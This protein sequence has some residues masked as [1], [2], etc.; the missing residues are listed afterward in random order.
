MKK[1]IVIFVLAA[2]MF[3]PAGAR[4]NGQ[5]SGGKPPNEIKVDLGPL[6]VPLFISDF[7][8]VIYAETSGFGMKALYD[9]NLSDRF[10]VG[11][12]FAFIYADVTYESFDAAI[13][14]IDAGIHGRYYPWKRFFYLQAGFGVVSFN[15][16]ISGTTGNLDRFQEDF[17]PYT[18][19]SGAFDAGFGWRFII[20]GHLVIDASV[21]SGFYLGNAL[22]AVTLPKLASGGLPALSGEFFPFRLDAAI[23]LGWA[24]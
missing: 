11:V 3:Q 7:M 23:A 4:E 9:R 22:S 2:V 20:G 8:E 21:L 16:D 1:S 12:D 6:F 10:S 18:G 5:A 15:F 24:F 17:A 14:S 19:V 13:R